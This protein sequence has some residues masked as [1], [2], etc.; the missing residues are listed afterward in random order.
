GGGVGGNECKHYHREP[1]TLQQVEIKTGRDE[2]KEKG[3]QRRTRQH[4]FLSAYLIN[5]LHGKEAICQVDDADQDLLEQLVV[6]LHAGLL[7]D[8]RSIEENRVRTRYLLKNSDADSQQ[9][10]EADTRFEQ[11]GEPHLEGFGG[12]T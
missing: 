5:Q 6:H 10:N 2:Y 4:H 7:K 9:H 3:H 1:V 8:H 12:K 11:P